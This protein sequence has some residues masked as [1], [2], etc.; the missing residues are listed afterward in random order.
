MSKI[1][2]IILVVFAGLL[3]SCKPRIYSFRT[4]PGTVY[5]A[6]VDAR[7]Q[8]G[9]QSIPV[10]LDAVQQLNPP[11]P[12]P[13]PLVQTPLSA[14]THMMSALPDETAAKFPELNALKND[15]AKIQ[16]L[17]LNIKMLQR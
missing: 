9:M 3:W 2:F 16:I 4:T 11:A 14:A 13:A 15:A 6:R 7:R 5:S 12:P 10:A 1:S 8:A 17:R